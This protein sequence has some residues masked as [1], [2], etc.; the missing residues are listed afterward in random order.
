MNTHNNGIKYN[1]QDRNCN[2][3][4]L[5]MSA[6]IGIKDIIVNIFTKINDGF[7]FCKLCQVPLN[8]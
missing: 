3:P 7:P 1:V 6:S 2:F 5:R 8:V 4:T